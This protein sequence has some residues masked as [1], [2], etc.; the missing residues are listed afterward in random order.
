ML[1]SMIPLLIFQGVY[2]VVFF[3]VGPWPYE[4]IECF[5]HPPVTS[6]HSISVSTGSPPI[7]LFPLIGLLVVL[8]L[9]QALQISLPV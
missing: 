6:S 7:L 8:I 1:E 3:Y 5:I 9:G 2:Y 4:K